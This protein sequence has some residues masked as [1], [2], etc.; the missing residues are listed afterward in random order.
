VAQGSLMNTL[1]RS[2]REKQKK[3]EAKEEEEEEE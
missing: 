3:R 1:G 2:L